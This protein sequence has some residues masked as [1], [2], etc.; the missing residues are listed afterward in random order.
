MVE[1]AC[2]KFFDVVAVL[3]VQ[4]LGFGICDLVGHLAVLDV[5]IPLGK[6]IGTFWDPAELV[7]L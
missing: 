3:L 7:L 5:I 4:D 6:K 1:G 2:L